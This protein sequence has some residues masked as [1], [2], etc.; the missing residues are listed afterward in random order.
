MKNEE[1]R[2]KAHSVLDEVINHINEMEKKT[3]TVADDLKHEY[4]QKLARLK[5]IKKDLTAKLDDYEVLTESRWDVVKESFDEFLD[6]VYDA[7][8]E[9]YKKAKSAF[10]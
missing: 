9:N 2:Q 6:Q 5:E 4:N 3:G 10:K 7:W 1:F 8:K